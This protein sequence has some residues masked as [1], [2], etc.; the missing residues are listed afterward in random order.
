MA[1]ITITITDEFD[2][3]TG[4]SVGVAAEFDPEVVKGEPITP[5]QRYAMWA[6]G[7]LAEYGEAGSVE[8]S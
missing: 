7:K 4:F 5:A 3:E 1:T 6:V 8:V 2:E